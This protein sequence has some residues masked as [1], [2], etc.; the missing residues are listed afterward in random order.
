[1]TKKLDKFE[2]ESRKKRRE[3][4]IMVKN[5][6][7]D[8]KT[9]FDLKIEREEYARDWTGRPLYTK[10]FNLQMQFSVSKRMY[11]KK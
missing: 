9:K 2:K 3:A 1:M 10:T 4:L 7:K 8:K 11:R 6:L 5:L